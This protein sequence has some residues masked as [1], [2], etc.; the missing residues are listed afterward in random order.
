VD[1]TMDRLVSQDK[2]VSNKLTHVVDLREFVHEK[3][4]EIGR[5]LEAIP[6]AR[7]APKAASTDE[8]LQRIQKLLDSLGQEEARDFT[9]EMEAT[10][11]R[12]TFHRNLVI[13]LA[14]IN[15]L[16]LVGVTF[17][18]VQIGKL[19]SLVTMCAWSKRVHY[20]GKW[21]PLEEYMRKRFGIRISHGISEEEYEKWAVP[22]MAEVQAEDR[23]EGSAPA[24][25]PHKAA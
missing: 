11:A 21:I 13:A 4:A 9:S 24:A 16:F 1:A 2:E 10:R 14:A 25:Q 3:L 15:V 5:S 12:A 18:A 8:D 23:G 17:C 22:E 7:T 20:E 19:H 6:Q